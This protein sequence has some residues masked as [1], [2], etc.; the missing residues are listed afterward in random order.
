MTQDDLE[1]ELR[2]LYDKYRTALLN[3][4][5]YGHKLE[6]FQRTNLIF[7]ML[8]AI[9]TSSAIGAWAIWRDDIGTI[10]WALL[11]GVTALI[12]VIKPLLQLPRKIEKYSKLFAGHGDVFY[13]LDALV[14]EVRER[15]ELTEEMRHAYKTAL[16]RIKKMAPQDDPRPSRELLDRYYFEVNREIPPQ[17]LWVPPTK[18]G[19]VDE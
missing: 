18:Q 15:K 16:N 9:G 11:T 17:N 6:S 7:E 1:A 4:K 5:Y 2:R 19:G 14:E 10:I 12:A 13:D 3:R 8:V